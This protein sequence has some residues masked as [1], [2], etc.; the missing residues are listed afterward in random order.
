MDNG[1]GGSL[2][3][4]VPFFYMRLRM[5]LHF[6][7]LGIASLG[8]GTR[9]LF[10]FLLFHLFHLSPLVNYAGCGWRMCAKDDP[11]MQAA[12]CLLLLL[13]YSLPLL[14][15]LVVVD[16]MQAASCTVLSSN[17]LPPASCPLPP[18]SC[19]LREETTLML[20]SPWHF[21]V[22][23]QQHPSLMLLLSL[24]SCW[25]LVGIKLSSAALPSMSS[26]AL[27]GPG[28]PNALLTSLM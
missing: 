12:S 20:V 8:Y 13:P 17:N 6:Q 7:E 11:H 1:D 18:A 27:P 22:G 25:L 4:G 26:N 9:S 3:L 15:L 5:L 16:H 28:Q 2:L 23:S 10:D 14:Q 19:L 24:L 21:L